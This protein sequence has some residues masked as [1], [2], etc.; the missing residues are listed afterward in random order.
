MP[1]IYRERMNEK[2]NYTYHLIAIFTVGVWGLTF[3]STKVLIA[4]GL[5]PKEIFLLRF[6][7][8]YIGI[9]F[10]SPR[11]L[12]ANNWK[13]ELWLLLGG[14]TGGSVYFLTENMAL[15]ITLATN[16]AFIV[17]TAPLLTTIFSLMIYKKE[18]ATR[19][20]IGGSLM[21]LVGVAM[22]VYNGSF[23]LKISPLGDFLTLLAAFS[24]AFY[25]LIMRKMSNCYGITFITRKIFFY[26]VLTI[27]P[28]FLI[29][30]WN[31]DIARLLEPAI[32]FNLLFLGVLASL[33]CFVVWNVI[34]K[35]LGTIRASNYI[36]LNPLFTL[37]GSA[38]LLG[39]Q[40]TIVAL[41]GAILILGG[42]YWAGKK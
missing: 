6:L 28:A 20:L 16:V 33:I 4:N 15:G 5:S 39:E 35:Q 27:L 25:S 24:W 10:I 36:Y 40:L 29:H 14:I 37:V 41:M 7:I 26:G 21:A 38:F 32:L 23:V 30:P 11:K 19:T 13:D 22:V 42:V 9:W 3:I 18:K 8:A 1:P 12:F 2:K 34:L 31:F 17:C